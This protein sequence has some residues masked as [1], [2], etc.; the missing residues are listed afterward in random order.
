MGVHSFFMLLATAAVPLWGYREI[1][2][3]FIF[4]LSSCLVHRMQL[5]MEGPQV[6]MVL[7]SLDRK[8][9]FSASQI[10]TFFSP[11]WTRNPRSHPVNDLQ[12]KL[13]NTVDMDFTPHQNQMLNRS[14][15]RSHH[16]SSARFASGRLGI[17]YRGTGPRR[18]AN[19]YCG[20]L[21]S[22]QLQLPWAEYV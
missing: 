6:V 7:A 18:C 22:C 15:W 17:W 4:F 14:L 2:D 12:T 21:I 16:P 5:G 13:W 19:R 20:I 10:V 3:H 1:T 8:I 9:K 11:G